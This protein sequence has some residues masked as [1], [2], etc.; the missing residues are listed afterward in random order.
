MAQKY[1]S[2]RKVYQ[3]GLDALVGLV[4]GSSEALG[5]HDLI[6][7]V[8]LNVALCL[9]RLGADLAA[10][11]EQCTLVVAREPRNVKALYRRAQVRVQRL[12]HTGAA[13]DYQ[14]ALATGDAD[15]DTQRACAAALRSCEAAER[16]H[17][18]KQRSAYAGAFTSQKQHASVCHRLTTALCFWRRAP[19]RE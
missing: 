16:A 8:R 11:E 14:A 19:K 6:T 10:A 5:Q 3:Q 18:H 17:T 9:L 13:A 15:D 1:K 12:D 4:A 2:A 7:P